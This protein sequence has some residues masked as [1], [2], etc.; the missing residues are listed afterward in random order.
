[1]SNIG[2]LQ[3]TYQQAYEDPGQ[4]FHSRFEELNLLFTR[5]VALIAQE[6]QI[7]IS[8]P[9]PPMVQKV[10]VAW[11]WPLR[12]TIIDF[13]FYLNIRRTSAIVSDCENSQSVLIKYVQSKSYN[14]FGRRHITHRLGSSGPSFESWKYSVNLRIIFNK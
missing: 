5:E 8:L 14:A 11:H 10:P 7:S 9:L 3:I 12:N 4:W 13:T 1:M 6:T 2:R